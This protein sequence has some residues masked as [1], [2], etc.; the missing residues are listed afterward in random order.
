MEQVIVRMPKSDEEKQDVQGNIVG[1]VIL[2]NDE[3]SF[4]ANKSIR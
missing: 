2:R 3:L 1:A 4:Q